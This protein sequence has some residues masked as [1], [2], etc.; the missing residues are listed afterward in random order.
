MFCTSSFL[1]K[2][3][4]TSKQNDARHTGRLFIHGEDK[5]ECC[6]LTN[7]S[8]NSF[9]ADDLGLLIPLAPFSPGT[10]EKGAPKRG[11]RRAAK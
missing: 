3:Q 2:A 11:L 5:P 4:N 8:S 1:L 10:G 6:S 7:Y 9:L